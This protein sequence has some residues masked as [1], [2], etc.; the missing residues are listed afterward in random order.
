[1]FMFFCKL[2]NK[3]EFEEGHV[4]VDIK[5]DQTGKSYYSN[6]RVVDANCIPSEGQEIKKRTIWER[7]KKIR[8]FHTEDWLLRL[9]ENELTVRRYT[10]WWQ[11]CL[12]RL[13]RLA[14]RLKNVVA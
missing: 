10:V 11:D 1:M 6:P 13:R 14:L 7:H 9:I 12:L 5:T 8:M 4:L 2:F 3:H